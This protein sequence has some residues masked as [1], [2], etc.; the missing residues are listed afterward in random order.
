[1]STTSTKET[2]SRQTLGPK[3]NSSSSNLSDTCRKDKK[4]HHKVKMEICKNK[5]KVQVLQY[6]KKYTLLREQY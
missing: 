5:T 2:R 6:S 1:M 4:E 3:R